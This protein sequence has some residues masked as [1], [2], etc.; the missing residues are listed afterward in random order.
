[1]YQ[2]GIQGTRGKTTTAYLVRSIFGA[3][4][5]PCGMVGSV[6]YDLGGGDLAWS[7]MTTPGHARLTRCF[8]RMARNGCMACVT[9]IA[10]R[11]SDGRLHRRR[12][13]PY[14]LD[15]LA[16]TNVIPE[17][18]HRAPEY[19]PSYDFATAREYRRAVAATFDMLRADGPVVLD[20]TD[21]ESVRLV[22]DST[23]AHGRPVM[24]YVPVPVESATLRGTTLRL[25]GRTVRCRLL[26]RHTAANCACS[27]ALAAVAGIR[28]ESVL[29][30]VAACP[31][32][33]G[34]MEPVAEVDGVTVVVDESHP[35]AAMRNTLGVLRS[36]IPAGARVHVVFGWRDKRPTTARR[37][38]GEILDAGADRVWL[39]ADG[40]RD[41]DPRDIAEQI[42]EGMTTR[43]KCRIVLDREAAACQ[44]VDQ[45][46]PGDVVLL[47]GRGADIVEQV[48]GG[49]ARVTDDAEIG[50]YAAR[51]RAW[52]I[53][54]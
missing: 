40:A 50:R 26:G 24:E 12:D 16:L 44:A 29:D 33:P 37:E 46:E 35:R 39:T 42:R 2:V 54:A 6:E 45:A 5:L 23:E 21:V 52:R 27:A 31:H 41:E 32:V 30:G 25:S 53:V 13:R 19:W 22:Q 18:Y 36:L 3:A 15:A 43:D 34:R 47:A 11:A 9:E 49:M 17:G 8:E 14:L 51:R 1:M 20:M 28:N 7:P 4:G 48:A 38:F 10:E